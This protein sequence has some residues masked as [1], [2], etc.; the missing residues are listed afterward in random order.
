[1]IHQYFDGLMTEGIIP[2]SLVRP[3]RTYEWAT[4]H[5][6]GREIKRQQ[7]DVLVDFTSEEGLQQ[8]LHTLNKGCELL[9]PKRLRT[10]LRQRHEADVQDLQLQA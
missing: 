3:E 4:F 6:D 1:M 9:S 8:V 5:V 10:H 2:C 7:I